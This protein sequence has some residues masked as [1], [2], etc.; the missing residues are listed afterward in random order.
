MGFNATSSP[1]CWWTKTKDLSLAP[2]VGPPAIVHDIIVMCLWRLLQTINRWFSPDVTAAML[3]HRTIEKRVFWEFDSIIMQN[4]SHNLLLFCARTW[5]SNHV[6]ENHL[7]LHYHEMKR[8]QILK[9]VT[10]QLA[11]QSR[12]LSRFLWHEATRSIFYSPL[13]G[14]AVHRRATPSIKFAGTH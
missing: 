4:M 11:H 6:I 12:G 7:P 9:S 14:M 3:V 8:H 5:P 13:D 2:F 10:S 1:P